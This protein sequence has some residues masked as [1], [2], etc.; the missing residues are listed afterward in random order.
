MPAATVDVMFLK[1]MDHHSKTMCACA[2]I[3]FFIVTYLLRL[4][5]EQTV[6]RVLIYVIAHILYFLLNILE[7]TRRSLAN[8]EAV[9][10]N[11]SVFLISHHRV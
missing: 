10:P 11:S 3:I 7:V 8:C 1:K 4:N 9:I 6:F 2:C 5:K